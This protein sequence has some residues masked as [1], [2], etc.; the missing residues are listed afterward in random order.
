MNMICVAIHKIDMN[1]IFV[2]SCVDVGEYLF[3]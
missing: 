1:A 2:S 3:T